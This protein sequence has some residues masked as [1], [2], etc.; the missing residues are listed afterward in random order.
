[1]V[2]PGRG[3]T[4]QM[5][6]LYYATALLLEA[7]A[8][9][10]AVDWEPEGGAQLV[11]LK[12]R[13][14]ASATSAFAAARGARDYERVTLVGKSLGA[15]AAAHLLAEEPAAAAARVVW[16]TPPLAWEPVRAQVTATADRSLLLVGDADALSDNAFVAAHPGAKH[17]VPGGDHSLAIPGDVLGSV[18]ALRGV[19]AAMREFLA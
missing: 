13:A 8:D 15:L 14:I 19:V 17:V 3:Y 4:R 1:V 9:V 10:L 2:L 12:V 5:P 6:L 11:E 18:D 16:L 7:R